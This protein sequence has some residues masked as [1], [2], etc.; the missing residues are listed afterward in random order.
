MTLA[1]YFWNES[2]C[3]M[4]TKYPEQFL[5]AVDH[6]T[7]HRFW[8]QFF[9]NKQKPMFTVLSL[10]SNNHVKRQLSERAALNK[11]TESHL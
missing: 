5:F 11:H 10:K 4:G 1:E 8:L 6:A 3:S 2:K 7:H 9:I